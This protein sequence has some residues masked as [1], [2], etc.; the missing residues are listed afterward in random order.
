MN[1]AEFQSKIQEIGTCEDE[2]LRRTKL[3]E[4]SDTVSEVFDNVDTLTEANNSLTET[5]DDLREANMQ[6]FKM[7]GQKQN[8]ETP[9]PQPEP[10]PKKRTYEN[11]FNEK[12]ELK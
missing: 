12:G 2:S 9:E 7:V 6:L 1:K 10:E 4:L 11:L 3:A 8:T 5:N